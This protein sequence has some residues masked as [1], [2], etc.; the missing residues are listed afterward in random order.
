[1][2]DPSW[3]GDWPINAGYTYSSGAVH[4][5]W[6]VGMPIGTPLYAPFDAVVKELNNGVQNNPGG[7]PGSG[8]PSNYRLLWSQEKPERTVYFQHMN[9]GVP[10]GIKVG[11]K[12]KAGTKIGTSG[13]TGNSTGPHLHLASADLWTLDQ[14]AYDDG[15]TASKYGPNLI[16]PP[17]DAWKDEDVALSQDDINK[18]AK[19]VWQIEVDVATGDQKPDVMTVKNALKQ[20]RNQAGIAADKPNAP[21]VDA[22]WNELL[23]SETYPNTKVRGALRAL[24][25]KMKASGS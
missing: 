1:M 14:Y 17:T 10:D 6:D 2:K 9:N 21:S 19:A 16:Y 23:D 13:N 12:I 25:E 8:A 4:A 7:S 11:A 22:I 18:I 15:C 3:Q 24:Y 20:S 5:A